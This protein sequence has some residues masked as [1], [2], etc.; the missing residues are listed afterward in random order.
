MQYYIGIDIGT[1]STK[2]A[3]VLPDGRIIARTEKSYPLQHPLEGWAELDPYALYD[4]LLS[5]LQQLLSQ[6]ENKPAFIAFSAAMHGLIAADASGRAITPCITWADTRAIGQAEQLLQTVGSSWYQTTGVPMHP[7]N[8]VAKIAWLQEQRPDLIQKT[9]CYCDIKSWLLLQL[10]GKAV[11]D[12]SCASAMG[13]RNLSTGSWDETICAALGIKPYQLPEM[14]STQAIFFVQPA[15]PLYPLIRQVP[16][17]AGAS[18]GALSNIGSGVTGTERVSLTIGTSAAVRVMV[19]GTHTDRA[20]RTFCYH[21]G[22]DQ[23]IQGGASN[24]GGILLQW[25]RQDLLRTDVSLDQ[26]IPTAAVIPPG[27]EGL[28]VL[29]YLLG[30][31]APIWDPRATASILG[32]RQQHGQAHLVRAVL[33][34][35]CYNCHQILQVLQEQYPIKAIQASG[36]FTQEP[37]WLQMMAD[38]SGLPVQVGDSGTD[39]ALMG[40]VITGAAATGTD[41]IQPGDLLPDQEYLPDGTRHL[42]YRQVYERFQ[43]YIRHGLQC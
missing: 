14:V 18:D 38:I 27:A 36:G 1:S 16:L 42:V 41:I 37:F 25:L 40:A 6:Q 28:L 31:R 43:Q 24:N 15:S 5:C 22:G 4:A 19:P 33:E 20:M 39:A 35:I 21:A 9:A 23:Y 3:V 12:S 11:L 34:S 13:L 10:T 29:P 7:M 32:L 30:E 26:L 17:V 8:P 2:A